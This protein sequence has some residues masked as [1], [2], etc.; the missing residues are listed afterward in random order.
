[1]QWNRSLRAG[2]PS[3]IDEMFL[4]PSRFA[5]EFP[6]VPKREGGTLYLLIEKVLPLNLHEPASGREMDPC[7]VDRQCTPGVT[8]SR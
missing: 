1:M 7:G 5:R 6:E 2:Q 3:C 4:K 8:I